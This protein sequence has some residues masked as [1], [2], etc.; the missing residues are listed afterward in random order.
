M[1][2]KSLIVWHRFFNRTLD[3][4]FLLHKQNNLI[5][6]FLI[7]WSAWF[8]SFSASMFPLF[9]L[10]VFLTSFPSPLHTMFFK[11][12]TSIHKKYEWNEI[13]MIFILEY[14]SHFIGQ[15]RNQSVKFICSDLVESKGRRIQF[16]LTLRTLILK[17]LPAVNHNSA[18]YLL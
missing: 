7:S 12:G 18:V 10:S 9:P 6:L 2:L 15:W 1:L 11:K 13:H 5:L 8:F 17:S 16:L 3:S 4:M 14:P